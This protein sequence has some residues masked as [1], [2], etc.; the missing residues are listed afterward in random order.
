[1]SRGT[2]GQDGGLGADRAGLRGSSEVPSGSQPTQPLSPEMPARP[3]RAH[4]MEPDWEEGFRCSLQLGHTGPHRD[5]GDSN[6]VNE[7]IDGRGRPY[8]WVNEWVWTP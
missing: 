4:L 2:G 7:S 3:C 8:M 6:G 1:M 5:E